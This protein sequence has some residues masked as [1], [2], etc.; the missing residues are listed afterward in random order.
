M[1]NPLASIS[2][3]IDVSDGFQALL[4]EHTK[5][6]FASVGLKRESVSCTGSAYTA[7]SPPAGA[8]AV[9]ILPGSAVSLT[10]KGVTGDTGIPIAP[11]SAPI[12]IPCLLPLGA[13]PTLGIAN[14]SATAQVVTVV[15]F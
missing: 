15:W 13:T 1:A 12:G 2:L 11:A 6:R 8:K 7:L 4:S 3:Q 14:A 9:A 5:H 10:L